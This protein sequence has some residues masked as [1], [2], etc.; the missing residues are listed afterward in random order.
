[1]TEAAYL[2]QTAETLRALGLT[3]VVQKTPRAARDA[4]A[5]AW[6]RVGKDRQGVDYAV[7]L[8]RAVAPATLG[9]TLAQLDQL[10]AV[11]ERPPLLV[12]AHVTPPLAERLRAHGRQFADTAGNAY[13]TGPGFLVFVAGRKPEGKA[14]AERPG[15]A[16]MTAGLKVLFALI[17][18]PELAAAP[19][20]AIAAAAGVALGAVP[21]VLADLRQ[22]GTLLVAGKKRRLH[23]TRRLLDDW[24]LAYARTL[25][26]KTQLGTYATPNFETWPDWKLE[27]DQARWGGEPAAHLLVGYLKPGV[28]MLYAGKLPARLMVE[29]RLT[30]AGLLLQANPYLAGGKTV[31]VRKPFWG[32]TLR[33]DGRPDTVPPA[34]VYAD[35]L[36]TGDA[37]CMETAWMVYDRHLARLFPAA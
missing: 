8:K 33:H 16:F 9:A 4:G 23:A 13:L 32:D 19:Q 35:L 11:A 3:V 25:R 37:R 27:P 22:Q 26:P 2:D 10:A 24:A 5:D 20:R 14:A 15:R 17:C 1:M 29:Q 34:L 30:R 31:E 7:A 28:L 36:A 21:P 12:T 18:D 6:L